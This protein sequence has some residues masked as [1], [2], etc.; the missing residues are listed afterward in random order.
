MLPDLTLLQIGGSK[1]N[2]SGENIK[3]AEEKANNLQIVGETLFRIVVWTMSQS[4]STS[5]AYA[6]IYFVNATIRRSN[7]ET[8]ITRTDSVVEYTV[9]ALNTTEN[10][11]VV[12]SQIRDDRDVTQIIPVRQAFRELLKRTLITTV[13]DEA[14][15]DLNAALTSGHIDVETADETW[16][17]VFDE[18]CED[19]TFVPDEPRV[20]FNSTSAA[21]IGTSGTYPIFLTTET[22][23]GSVRGGRCFFTRTHHAM[24][25]ALWW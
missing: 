8:K 7:P 12:I 24:T 6:Q 23:D 1:R 20:T 17:Q 16:I 3:T 18:L 15:N 11:S 14:E 22:N 10:A 5:I 9:R 25:V 19:E 4:D 2:Y 13:H 21:W